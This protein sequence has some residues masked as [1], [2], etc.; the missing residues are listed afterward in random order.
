MTACSVTRT[1]HLLIVNA[2]MN[3]RLSYMFNYLLMIFC[4]LA[5]L[6]ILDHCDAT[7]FLQPVYNRHPINVLMMTMI[8]TMRIYDLPVPVYILVLLWYI[9]CLL[10][11]CIVCHSSC[12]LL[13]YSI[14]SASCT[15]GL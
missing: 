11:L 13:I 6:V 8:V 5:F 7:V 10:L 3:F 1:L 12:V 9:K 2:F 15:L 4:V 14:I